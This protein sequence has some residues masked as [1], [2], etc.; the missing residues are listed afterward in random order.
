MCI[1][2]S[3]WLFL[4]TKGGDPCMVRETIA[5]EEMVGKVEDLL[6]V[7]F[8]NSTKCTHWN[9]QTHTCL[10]GLCITQP[11]DR[12]AAFT[13]ILYVVVLYTH[14]THSLDMLQGSG[15]PSTTREPLIGGEVHWSF[16]R[17]RFGLC[18]SSFPLSH[19]LEVSCGKWV[20]HSVGSLTH[21]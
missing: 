11:C 18:T 12:E 10:L 21:N 9:K 8:G 6:S 2:V 7:L 1:W 4:D 20:G 17:G 15:S 5:S 19:S 3:N 13:M 16:L 14:T